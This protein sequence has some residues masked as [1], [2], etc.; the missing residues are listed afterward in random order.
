MIELVLIIPVKDII[1]AQENAKIRLRFM[2]QVEIRCK[3]SGTVRI[4]TAIR[5]TAYRA[6]K[7]RRTPFSFTIGQTEVKYL[8]GIPVAAVVFPFALSSAL[9]HV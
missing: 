4:R 3:I 1:D 6:S 7:K 2:A 9:I 5:P 8:M